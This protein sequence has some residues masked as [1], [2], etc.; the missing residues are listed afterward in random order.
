MTIDRLV[1]RKLYRLGGASLVEKMALAG[2]ANLEQRIGEIAGARATCDHRAV[3]LAAHSMRSSAGNL[4]LS[5]LQKLG[6]EIEAASRAQ[7]DKW[8]IEIEKA[9]ELLSLSKAELPIVLRALTRPKIAIVEDNPDNR[10]LL[11]AL[12]EDRFDICVF[13]DGRVALEGL[14]AEKPDLLLLDISLPGM[15]GPTLLR[16]L[17]ADE[18]LASLPIVALT[19]HAM[20]GDR[21]RFLNMGFDGYLSKPIVDENDLTALIDGLLRR[22]G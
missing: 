8:I 7:E 10:L 19:A 21:E 13:E 20:T 17:R 9:E 16:A 2:L 15:D 5:D 22:S 14:K 12:L 18:G 4:G 1:L 6:Q 11:H 3:E